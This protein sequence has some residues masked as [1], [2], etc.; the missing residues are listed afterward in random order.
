MNQFVTSL[1]YRQTP[2]ISFI[3]HVRIFHPFKH[4]LWKSDKAN[5]LRYKSYS[6]SHTLART[7]SK[8]F[9]RS[10]RARSVYID[11]KNGDKK[12]MK[13]TSG[14]IRFILRTDANKKKSNHP[15]RV[16]SLL[17]AT[18]ISLFALRTFCRHEL[19]NKTRI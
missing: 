4:L 19:Y 1:D 10:T 13:H 17:K 3:P 18:N 14:N 8:K 9:H 16:I 5:G 6:L 12:I 2:L 15:T 7:K 11:A